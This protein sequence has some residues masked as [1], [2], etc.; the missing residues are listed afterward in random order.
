M[1]EL[2]IDPDQLDKAGTGIEGASEQLAQALE[3]FRATIEGIGDAAGGDE[4]GGLIGDAHQL[5]Y[6]SAME[7]FEDAVQSL[8]DAGFD[9]RDFGVQHQAADDAIAKLFAGL[10]GEIGG[11][12]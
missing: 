8:A 7:T 4:I 2:Q 10:Q 5:I 12:S 6:E 11:G 3:E 1:S 9:V